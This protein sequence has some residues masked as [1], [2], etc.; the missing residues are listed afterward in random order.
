MILTK[1]YDRDRRC[2]FSC[3]GS[4][5]INTVKGAW[6]DLSPLL[7]DHEV[8]VLD[9]RQIDEVDTA[10]LQLLTVLKKKAHLTGIK[11]KFINHSNPVLRL[12]ELFGTTGLFR[13]KIILPKEPGS[14]GRFRYGISPQDF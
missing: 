14:M 4:L 7:D 5:S 8:V 13:D 3:T 2:V 11:I 12:I 1:T 9:L 10:G 6:K